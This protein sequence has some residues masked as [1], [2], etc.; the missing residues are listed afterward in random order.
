[1]AVH[2]ICLE[3]CLPSGITNSFLTPCAA[4]NFSSEILRDT[5]RSKLPE[6]IEKLN[7]AFNLIP[8]GQ[9]SGLAPTWQGGPFDQ[10]IIEGEWN[11]QQQALHGGP[12]PM[13]SGAPGS[14]GKPETWPHTETQHMMKIRSDNSWQI[15]CKQ[16]QC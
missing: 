4:F 6:Y 3:R 14:R 11:P 16:K 9:V 1:M 7:E 13:M 8:M 5:F 2:N 10:C 15:R 12:I